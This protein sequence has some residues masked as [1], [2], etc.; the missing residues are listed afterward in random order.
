MNA[1][2]S[3]AAVGLLSLLAQPVVRAAELQVWTARVGATVLAEIGAEFERTTGHTLKLSVDLP[4]PFLQRI[5]AGEQFD[6]LI[7]TAGPIDA[8][9]KEG[10]LVQETRATFARSGIGVQVRKGARKPDISSVEAFK[11]AVLDAKSIAYLRIGSGA[12]L[13]GL[14]ERMGIA[15]SIAAKVTRPQTDVVSEMVARGEVELGMVVSTQILTTPGVDFV[16]PLPAQIQHYIVFVGAVSSASKAPDAARELLRF[17]RSPK[18]LAVM[19]AQG[20]QAGMEPGQ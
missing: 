1:R 5:N 13:H 4:E 2:Y 15:E 19:K 8:L 11:R 10:R 3:A 16:G 9:I 7:S 6:V 17:L 14:F 12:Y 20:M 18:A